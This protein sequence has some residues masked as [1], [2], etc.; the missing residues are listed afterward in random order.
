MSHADRP[1]P[2]KWPL[3]LL[4]FFI[5]DE[6]LEEI[7]GD[8]EEVFRDDLEIYSVAKARR[9]YALESLKLIRPGL[10]R[11]LKFSN[12]PNT[13]DMF[14]NYFKISLRNFVKNK[15]YSL[16]N[17]GG[18]V[19][20]LI[21]C[22][23]IGLHILQELSYDRFHPAAGRTYRVVMDMF[24]NGELK[25]KSA[26]VY[27]AVG[28]TLL[29][30]FPEVTAYTRILPFGNGVYSYRKDGGPLVRYNENNAVLADVGFFRQFGFKLLKGDPDR[31]LAQKDQVVIS[32][33][34]ALKYFGDEDPI[35]KTLTRRGTD[36]LTVSGVMADFPENSHMDFD[37]IFSMKSMDDFAE[38]PENWGWYD[39]YTF[40]ELAPTASVPVFEAKLGALLDEKKAKYYQ[41]NNSREVL[42]SQ[43]VEDIHL[44][45]Q[46]LSWD[47]GQNGGAYQIYFLGA[48]ALLILVIAWVNFINLSTARAVK[49][50][51]EVGIRKVVG[52]GK[53]QL[54]FQFLTE[55]LLYNSL[56]VLV[57]VGALF[58]LIRPVNRL[59]DTSLSM[60][61]LLQPTILLG[62][63]GLILVGALL[64][65]LYPA[66]IL[67]SFRPL[68]VLKGR[69]YNR[70]SS[71][72]FRQ[73]LVVFQFAI[74]TVLILGTFIV[75]KQLRFMQSYDLGMNMEQTLVLRAPS[76][77][78]EGELSSRLG[79]FRQTLEELPAVQGMTIS[80]SIPGIENFG[81]SGFRSRHFPNEDRDCYRIRVDDA[82]MPEFEIDV[83]A[84]RNFR[85]EM[86]SDSS[87]V[88]LNAR[89]AEHLGFASP[90]AAVG[91]KVNP[92]SNYEWNII[93]VVENYY[94]ESIKEDL[95]PI[96][97]FHSPDQGRYYSL[98]IQADDAAATIAAIESQW[99]RIYPDNPF[100]FFFLDENFASQYA[101]DRRFNLIFIG[102]ASLAIFVACLG[103]FGLISY[104]VEQNRK[105]I[106]IRKILGASAPQII[107]NLAGDYLKLIL[108]AMIVAFP[109]AYY[110]MSRW[111]D[112][113]AQRT[114][115]GAGMFIIGAGLIVLVAILTV[116][117][118][119][120]RAATANPIQALREE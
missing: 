107:R 18:L 65:G 21:C 41:E 78:A 19:L 79:L 85:E 93:G 23:L 77:N 48:V 108:I 82:F 96:I 15:D 58:L 37:I 36:E 76:S 98:K 59:F 88:L 87:A 9:L 5:R 17:L 35:G 3:Q 102:F 56:A 4:R 16:I 99:D 14:K 114:T 40:V 52:A 67:S 84:G 101:A 12:H 13:V 81:I 100:D 86:R 111:L 83:L 45:S 53:R 49:R 73:V 2:P 57:A 55:A 6:Y 47:M 68:N 10:V 104:T 75:V 24:G 32:E 33:S 7:E 71:F 110:L 44:Y 46:G 106:G 31:V 63:L 50:A 95:D 43:A 118:K 70:K 30:E 11:H 66:Y 113:F 34:T 54:V 38:L 69:F 120:Y 26:P 39:F 61:T 117:G 22:L 103:L 28:P 27:P 91:E 25:T 112:D 20:G 51:K 92:G 42:W 1:M 72:G 60:G 105:E 64:S 62:L 8:M 80:S 29:E 109:L 119:S 115:I 90:E 116:S 89:A 94:Q 74:S 97:F